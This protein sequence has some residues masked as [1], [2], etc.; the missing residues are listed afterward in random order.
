ME[1]PS[2]VV[3]AQ[4]S[5]WRANKDRGQFS[6]GFILAHSLC[7]RSFSRLDWAAIFSQALGTRAVVFPVD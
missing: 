4:G 1:A 7:N 3:K 6:G 2:C 5:L